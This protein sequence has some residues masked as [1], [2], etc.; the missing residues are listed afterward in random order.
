[1]NPNCNDN[2]CDNVALKTTCIKNEKFKFIKNKE[3]L[4]VYSRGQEPMACEP[5]VALL[6]MAFGSP[7]VFLT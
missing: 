3:R 6:M 5:D 2:R 7:D 4:S 1:M